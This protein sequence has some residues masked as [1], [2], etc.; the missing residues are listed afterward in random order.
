M[1]VNMERAVLQTQ[2]AMEGEEDRPI[3]RSDS[4]SG[5][6]S[7]DS[8][9]PRCPLTPSLS[10]RK[11]TTSQSK[12][13]PPLLRTNKRT[14]YTAGRPPWYNVTG[15]TFKEAFVIGL[16]GGSASGKTTVA[17]KI[18]EALD[19]P[20]VVLLSMDS[21]YKVLSK[22]EQELA[23][24]N[25]Y[26]FDHPDAFDFEL[27][28]TVLRKLKK[29]KSIKVPVYDFTTHSR[30]KEWKT[31]YG[32]NVVIFEGILA[33][34]NK[35]L[36]KLLDMKVFVDTDSDIRLVRRLK[37]DITNRGRDITGVIKQYNKFV[38]PAFEQYIEPTMQV[39][40]IVV[41]R[42]GE[43]FVALDLIVQHVHSQLEK[44]EITVRAALATAHQGQPLP[45]TL[46]VME[47]TPQ[48]RGLHTI[49]RNKE[50][51]RDEFIFYSKRLMR[52]LIE[53]AL[54]FLPLKPVTVETPQGAIYEGKRLG[55]KRITGVSILRAGE[56]MEQALMAVCKDIRLGK[57]LIQTNHDTGEPELH[58]LRLPKDISEDYVI[59]MD[60]TVSTG[61]AALMAV[62][63]LLDHDVQE[64]KIFLLSLLMAEMGV[65]SVAYAF[66]K[67][68]IITTAVDKNVN[69]EFHIIPGIGNFG[70]RYFGTDAPSG[71]E[72]DGSM[73]Y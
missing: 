34:A 49:I 63:V 24:K 47:S 5:E 42:G 33:F 30:R 67:V 50:T 68:R 11:R 7:L 41:P 12:T 69:N 10:P 2:P 59:L 45:K 35:E 66:P 52:L 43:N 71:Y 14:I 6:D 26:N 70:D 53:H 62:R 18:I 44:R 1:A 57:I 56:T 31:I 54:S 32:A 28:V 23:A 9:F 29:G 3:S 65:H 22:E 13:E 25:E 55:G 51:N 16:C 61:A 64:D 60:S 38:K 40:D 20:W 8:L 37:R 72:S 73:D 36:L 48:V 17:N 46:S 27:L 58:Y 39:A 15:T 21:F 19:V 4:G